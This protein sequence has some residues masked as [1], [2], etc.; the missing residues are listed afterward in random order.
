MKTVKYGESHTCPVCGKYTFEKAGQ[1]D[2]CDVCDWEDDLVQLHYPD[3]E[4][5]ANSMSLNQAKV[6]WK[7][8]IG[9]MSNSEGK[10]I[11]CIEK[12]GCKWTGIVDVYETG[13]DNADDEQKGDFICVSRDDGLNVIVYAKDIDIIEILNTDRR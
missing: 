8:K 6:A 11:R 4:N 12:D 13:F 3:E 7:N 9:I 1:F 5:C 10:R 2:I